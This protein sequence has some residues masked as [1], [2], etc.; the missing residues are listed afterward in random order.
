VSTVR[1]TNNALERALLDALDRLLEALKLNPLGDDRF[2]V[3]SEPSR[4]DRVYGGQTL[5]QALVAASATVDGKQPHSLHGYFAQAGAPEQPIDLAVDRVRDGRS[6]STRQVKVTQGDRPLLVAMVSF[7]DNPTEPELTPT[8]PAVAAPDDLPILQKWAKEAPPELLPIASLWID[9]PPPLELRIGEAPVYMGG[10]PGPDER[11]H[12]MRLPAD[13][14]DEPV[15]HSALLAYASDYLL[16]DMAMRTHPDADNHTSYTTFSLDHAI[17]F[18]RP[19]DF[20]QWHLY[21]QRTLALSGHRALV[22]GVIRDASGH[23]VA[24]AV[25]ETLLRPNTRKQS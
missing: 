6:M 20:R 18:H 3:V 16:L 24:T 2:Q 9:K 10:Q 8:V 25:Q 23:V 22:H 11:H 5:A 1:G 14:G 7:H 21:T 15:L 12:W 4:S 13:I 19:V 17:W